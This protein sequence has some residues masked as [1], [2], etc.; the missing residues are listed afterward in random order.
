MNRYIFQIARKLNEKNCPVDNV[1]VYENTEKYKKQ[2]YDTLVDIMTNFLPASV[3]IEKHCDQLFENFIKRQ[4]CEA[5]TLEEHK[6]ISDL[7]NNYAAKDVNILH[8]SHGVENLNET[9]EKNDSNRIVTGYN[10][11][12][13]IAGSFIGGDYIAVGARPSMGKTAFALNVA[14]MLC[15]QNY[16]VL[17][18][19]LEM[20]I[21]QLQNRFICMNTG[22]NA[23]KI[24]SN[25]FN[26]L[27]K[28][29]YKKGFK[30]LKD[31]NLNVTAD[32]HMTPEKLRIYAEKMK[33]AGKLDFLVIDYLGL[34]DGDSENNQNSRLTKFSRCLKLIAADLN[35][36][37]M[38][39]IQLNRQLTNRENKR[40]QLSDLRDS[41]AMEQDADFVIFLHREFMFTNKPEQERDLEV[42]F[43][44]NRHGKTNIIARMDFNTETQLI[45]EK[46]KAS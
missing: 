24:R 19:S 11:F 39:L 21:L 29:R 8:I 18:I 31:F 5:K 15:I 41:G 14:K 32:F 17:F 40:P 12:D 6:K 42:I 13:D 22:L 3:L 4:I 28:E 9:L 1:V 46:T 16:N 44:K 37:V 33:D 20:P 38:V 27:E 34:M 23:H 43:R 10:G 30:D 35:I 45:T 26:L 7:Q 36:P 2:V 25:S